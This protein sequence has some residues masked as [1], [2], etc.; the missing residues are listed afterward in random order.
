MAI[1][2]VTQKLPTNVVH[3]NTYVILHKDL[4]VVIAHDG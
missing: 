3:M 2:D 4:I 1:T